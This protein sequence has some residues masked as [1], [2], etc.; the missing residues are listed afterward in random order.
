MG[1]GLEGDGS[2]LRGRE[3]GEISSKNFNVKNHCRIQEMGK[4]RGE[5]VG[6]G[7]VGGRKVGE[8]TEIG[9]KPGMG[10]VEVSSAAKSTTWKHHCGIDSLI[11]PLTAE[12]CSQTSNGE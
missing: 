12:N 9:R 10:R 8:G 2:R 1:R 7:G 3:N 5:G 6:R 4:E 11:S